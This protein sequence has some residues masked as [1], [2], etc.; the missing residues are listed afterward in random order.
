MDQNLD[1]SKTYIMKSNFQSDFILNNNIIFN[2]KSLAKLA[3]NNEKLSVKEFIEK[4][5][6]KLEESYVDKFWHSIEENDEII[7]D[8]EIIRW[9]GYEGKIN[10]CRNNIKKI[11]T[12][13]KIIF[14]NIKYSEVCKFLHTLKFETKQKKYLK[15]MNFMQLS[16]RNF[17]DLCMIINT[18]KGKQIRNY[19]LDLEE[20]FKNYIKYQQLCDK[21]K[22]HIQKQK[23]IKYKNE[24][25]HYKSVINKCNIELNNIKK[26]KKKNEIIYIISSKHY[27]EQGL[28]KIG[29]SNNINSR[30]ASLNTSHVIKDK[31]FIVKEFKVYDSKMIE[32]RIKFILK[33]IRDSENREFYHGVY[34]LLEKITEL[35]CENLDE[36]CKMMNNIITKLVNLNNQSYIKWTEGLDMSIFETEKVIVKQNK[37]TKEII[38][39]D[40]ITEEMIKEIIL[41]Y[42]NNKTKCKNFKTFEELQKSIN[43]Y[44]L[45]QKS[46]LKEINKINET[47]MTRLIEIVKKKKWKYKFRK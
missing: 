14:Q 4:T 41:F 17:K 42:F 19:Y 27:A 37:E 20:L 9:L 24:I 8:D 44:K 45:I 36:E 23:T 5:E 25:N 13:N 34:V 46:K 10:Y 39:D 35:I 22:L 33:N 30:L 32:N 43:N 1:I 38:I 12:K 15:Q 47:I 6:Y 31:L 11:L 3:I 18:N 21:F 16:S 7:L 28:F 29:R 26:F 2:N 40:D